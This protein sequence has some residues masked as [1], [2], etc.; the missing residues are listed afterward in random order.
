VSD[1]K[2]G[3]KDL[4]S[5]LSQH[6]GKEALR[7]ALASAR[8]PAVLISVL[9]RYVQFNSAF[10]AGL[11]N[12]AGEIAAR[13]GL[14]RDRDEPLLLAA[15]RAAEVAS[16]FFYGAIDEFDDRSTPWRDTHRTLAQATLKG[17]GA[18]FG[19]TPQ[20]LNTVIRLN[21]ITETA[22]IR[23]WEG[24]GVGAQLE[25]PR[26][27]GAMG[28]HTGSE[29]LADEEF[30]D[31]DRTLKATR[32]ELV[33]ALKTMKVE[34]AGQKH[35]AYYWIHIHTSVEADH[36]DAALRGA[37]KALRFYAGSG[38]PAAVKEWILEGF[39]HF[40]RVQGEFMAG[41]TEP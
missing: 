9:A 2:V 40:A 19:Y 30:T 33:Q 1:L 25:E 5:V 14:F 10:G 3:R 11:A 7:A 27:F 38:D 31:I 4:E 29:V 21:P 28:F 13:Q 24:Y 17:V 26:L 32:P 15:D 18:Y 6:R 8:E 41:L 36:F 39:R 22:L 12:L 16:D 34:H 35:D 23:V 37:N 20:Q